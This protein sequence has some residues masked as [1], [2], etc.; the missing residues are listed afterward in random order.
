MS[1]E[2]KLGLPFPEC[3]ISF[4]ENCPE[5]VLVLDQEW[6]ILYANPSFDRRFLTKGS[7]VGTRLLDYLDDNS[8]LR[9]RDMQDQIFSTPMQTELHHSIPRNR[10][11]S[12]HYVFFSLPSMVNGRT[13]VGA[14]ARDRAGDLATLLETIN[15]NLELERKQKELSDANARLEQLSITDQITQLFSRDHFFQL[16]Q[17]SWEESRRYEFPLTVMMMDLDDFKKVNDTY[18]HIFGDYVLKQASA[19][20]KGRTRKADLLARYGGEEIVLLAS[21]TDQKTGFLLAERLRGA[22]DSDPF[23]MGNCTATVTISIG[24]SGTELRNFSSFEDLLESSDQALY[25]AKRAGKNCVYQYQ[26]G[27]ADKI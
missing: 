19:R 14:I 22:V 16:A 20:L 9:A 17:H 3:G 4:F 13:I 5:Y 25:A 18:G 21:N 24:V 27:L 8:V 1:E 15:L 23:T 11:A 6:S 26:H 7:A 10:T 2:T 12:I